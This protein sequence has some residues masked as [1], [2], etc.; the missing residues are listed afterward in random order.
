MT[1]FVIGYTATGKTP[2]AQK[3][4]NELGYKHIS[5]SEWVKTKFK[6]SS[7]TLTR[8]EYVK[9]IT[10]YSIEQLKVDPDS[11]V[12]YIIDNYREDFFNGTLVIDGVR[13]PRD[14][15]KLFYSET[16]KVISLESINKEALTE[17]EEGVQVIKQYCLWLINN[18]L[19]EEE[20]TKIVEFK[21]RMDF[22]KIIS[23]VI[24]EMELLK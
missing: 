23:N 17:F 10:S 18:N 8:E 6:A 3:L 20:Q 2:F 19:I 22:D 12:R 14:F 1:I 24:K 9:E 11:C 13:N 21:E 7:E 16:D 15:M 5:A 4:A